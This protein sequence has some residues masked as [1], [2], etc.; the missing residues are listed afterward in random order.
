MRSPPPFFHP[1]CRSPDTRSQPKSCASER[2]RS[3]EF[4][5]GPR[6]HRGW[7]DEWPPLHLDTNTL[8]LIYSFHNASSKQLGIHM[9]LFDL[10]L[11]EKV[12]TCVCLSVAKF[13]HP[14]PFLLSCAQHRTPSVR[15]DAEAGWASP[16]GTAKN[17]GRHR[18]TYA[19]Y[20][21]EGILN[22][23][24]FSFRGMLWFVSSSTLSKYP[25]LAHRVWCDVQSKSFWWN[26][27]RSSRL[28]PVCSV[29]S[30]LVQFYGIEWYRFIS[31]YTVNGV[32]VRE[33]QSLWSL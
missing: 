27:R 33:R 17:R 6:S 19:D 32:A 26:L 20:H 9:H 21:T 14:A 7:F 13:Q 30:S 5:V 16:G 24:R 22:V 15:P 1:L 18:M 23:Q 28:C 10:Y 25:S 11:C 31:I 2:G 8:F 4:G 12:R 3:L 29:L